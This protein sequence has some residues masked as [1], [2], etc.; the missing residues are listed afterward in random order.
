[1]AKSKTFAP[2]FPNH[3]SNNNEPIIKVLNNAKNC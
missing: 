3:A 2:N 1:M